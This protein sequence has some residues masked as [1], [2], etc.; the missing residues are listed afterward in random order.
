M[1]RRRTKKQAT[2]VFRGG[3]D[4][5]W[6]GQSQDFQ[7]RER[8]A[9]E[10]SVCVCPKALLR[11]YAFGTCLNLH[12]SFIAVIHEADTLKGGSTS[13]HRTNVGSPKI[14]KVSNFQNML[15]FLTSK[16]TRSILLHACVV[17]IKLRINTGIAQSSSFI[18]SQNL[19][20]LQKNNIFVVPC[21]K[22]QSRIGNP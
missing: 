3:L 17:N 16:M 8:P 19:R 5:R 2:L 6:R 20:L 14:L 1:T 12:F 4:S 10:I 11:N 18:S 7:S 9:P 21:T 15:I 13:V 22:A